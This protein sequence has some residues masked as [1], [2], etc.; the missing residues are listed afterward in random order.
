MFIREIECVVTSHL[1]KKTPDPDG[2]TG[3]FHQASEEEI[4]SVLYKLFQKIEEN[5]S[6]LILCEQ[7]YSNDQN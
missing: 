4:I 2:F 3:E 5:T 1:I 6:H 7:H